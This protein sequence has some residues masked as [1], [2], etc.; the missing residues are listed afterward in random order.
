MVRLSV[1]NAPERHAPFGAFY[2]MG[3]A[4]RESHRSHPS[5][6]SYYRLIGFPPRTPSYSPSEIESGREGS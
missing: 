1:N 2:Y 4:L 3:Q 6:H 5:A